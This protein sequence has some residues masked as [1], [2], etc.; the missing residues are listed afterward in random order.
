MADPKLELFNNATG[1]KINENNDWATPVAPLA[2]SAAQLVSAF[3]IVA[4]FQLAN[5]ST[6][7]AA[8]LVTLAPGQYSARVSGAD[9]GGGTVI[10]EV[11][12]AP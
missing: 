6:K 5:A 1:A 2:T 4:A 8:L 3:D 7:D 12:E 10:V 9:G 11:Y